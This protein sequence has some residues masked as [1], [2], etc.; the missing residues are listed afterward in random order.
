MSS[1]GTSP[2]LLLNG[3]DALVN[4]CTVE[5]SQQ[6]RIAYSAP[7]TNQL[8]KGGDIL[9]PEA[10]T[11][12]ERPSGQDLIPSAIDRPMAEGWRSSHAYIIAPACSHIPLTHPNMYAPADT[13]L[14]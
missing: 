2:N 10:H 4:V 5:T 11:M 7:S 8:T 12:H 6:D 3:G 13:P 9:S 14:S 1:C